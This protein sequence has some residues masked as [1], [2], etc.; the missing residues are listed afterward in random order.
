M[1]AMASSAPP[2]AAARRAGRPGAGRGPA[3]G[4]PG[5]SETASDHHPG[6]PRPTRASH[7]PSRPRTAFTH[8]AP[9]RSDRR[10]PQRTDPFGAR[11]R[12]GVLGDVRGRVLHHDLVG[13]EDV[14]PRRGEVADHD[15]RDVGLEE[16][17]RRARCSRRP[18]APRPRTPRSRRR[19]AVRAMVPATTVPSRRKVVVPSVDLWARAW[20]DGVEVVERAAEALDQEEDHRAHEDGE[21][22]DEARAGAA[23]GGGRRPGAGCRACRRTL[24]GPCRVGCPD[25]SRRASSGGRPVPASSATA[26]LE[27][28]PAERPAR[29]RRRPGPTGR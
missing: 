18:P 29:R 10:P 17:R 16:L 3:R 6:R 2:R 21:D 27:A 12:A 11:T 1:A 24:T 8:A 19:A 14:G 15:H 23:A 9:P 28:T 25:P 7:T 13:H 26:R 5:A 20:C 4:P 22:H